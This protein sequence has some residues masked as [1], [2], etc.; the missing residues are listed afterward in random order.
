MIESFRARNRRT[1]YPTHLIMPESDFNGLAAQMSVTY[2]LRTKISLLE[3]AFKLISM[4]PNFKILPV[5]YADAAFHPNTP[6]I[7]GKNVYAL[8]NFDP[9]SIVMNIPVDYTN[10]A[11]NTLNG[12]NFQSVGYGQFTGVTVYR[13]LEIQYFTYT[14]A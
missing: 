7:A 13:P 1:A 10:T 12:F 5:A 11:Q 8:Y 9:N 2:P 4:N 6:G 14:P 3:E